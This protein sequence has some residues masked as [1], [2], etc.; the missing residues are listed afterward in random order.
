MTTNGESAAKTQNG[1]GAAATKI[2]E[3]QLDV[4][5]LLERLTTLEQRVNELETAPAQD[6]EDRLSMVVFSGDLD[7]AIAAKHAI[8]KE[9]SVVLLPEQQSSASSIVAEAMTIIN[10][11]NKKSSDLL[12]I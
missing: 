3:A 5:T 8:A 7:K 4:T 1:N 9:S 2:G 10:A 6:I 12:D 11:M